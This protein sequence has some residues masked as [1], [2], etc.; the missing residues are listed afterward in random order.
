MATVLSNGAPTDA[1]GS[2]ILTKIRKAL[3]IVHSP[4]SPNESRQEAQSF[5]EHVKTLGEAPSFGNTLASEKTQGPVIR[6]YGLSLLEHAV[7]HRWAEYSESQRS[8][9]RGWILQ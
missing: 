4:Y 5:L 9:L 7:K 8:Y 1:A 3:E 6:H 2:E